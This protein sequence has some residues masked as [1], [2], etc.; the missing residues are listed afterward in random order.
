MLVKVTCRVDIDRE[1]NGRK[2]RD[3]IYTN[4]CKC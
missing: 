3:E 2:S 1:V 4:Y